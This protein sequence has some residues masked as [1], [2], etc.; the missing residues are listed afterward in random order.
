M[1]L[2]LLFSVAVLAS[3]VAVPAQCFQ[4][5]TTK[6]IGPSCNFG[7]TGF[8]LVVSRPTMLDVAL[9]AAPCT[10]EMQ[11]DIFEGCGATVPLRAIA[12]GVQP[13]NLPLP[14]LGEGCALHLVPIVIVP[15]TA[16]PLVLDL[17]PGLP[18]FGFLAQALAVSVP[19]LEPAYLTLSDGL[20]IELR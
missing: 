14:Q 4:S 16:K 1:K 11:V 6:S 9:G 10:L 13:A 2:S 3:A 17:P 7:S 19:P 8:C 18:P 5:V 12:I 15:T 20:S